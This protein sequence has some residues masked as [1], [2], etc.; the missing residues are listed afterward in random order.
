MTKQSWP[1]EPW[2]YS[3]VASGRNNSLVIKDADGVIVCTVATR[4]KRQDF[5]PSEMVIAERIVSCVNWCKQ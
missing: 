2:K 3:V 1:I 4:Q 5:T